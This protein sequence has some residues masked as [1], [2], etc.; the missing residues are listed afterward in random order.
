[1]PVT[2]REIAK[3][4]EAILEVMSSFYVP[5]AG[6]AKLAVQRIEE[7]RRYKA[8]QELLAQ[9]LAEAENAFLEKAKEQGLTDVADW[10]LQMPQQNRPAFK[11]ALEVMLDK[12]SEEPLADLLASEFDSI[13]GLEE[14]ERRRAAA[15]YLTCL[16]SFLLRHESYRPLITALSQLRSEQDARRGCELAE[17]ILWLLTAGMQTLRWPAQPYPAG[18]GL[19][20]YILLAKYRLAPYCG[21]DFEQKRQD[22]LAWAQGLQE[23]RNLFGLRL[24]CGPGGG[25]KTRLLIEAGAALRAA[26]WRVGFVAEAMLDERNAAMLCQEQPQRPTLLILD[27]VE[28][29]Q[30]EVEALLRQMADLRRGNQRQAALAAVLLERR[31]PAWLTGYLNRSRDPGYVDWVEFVGEL[32]P[33]TIDLPVLQ[34][35]EAQ[36]LFDQARQSFAETG[37]LAAGEVSYPA[38]PG[39][40]L[41]VLL[42]AL[43]AAAGRRLEGELSPAKIYEFTWQRERE[44]WERLLRSQA[45]KAVNPDAFFEKAVAALEDLCVLATLGRRFTNQEDAGAFLKAHAGRWQAFGPGG[46]QLSLDWLAGCLP[47]LFPPGALAETLAIA[48]DPLADFVLRLRLAASPELLDLALPLPEEAAQ[49]PEPAAAVFWE[50]L[51]ALTRLWAGEEAEPKRQVTVWIL[52]VDG[53]L[54]KCLDDNLDQNL[55]QEF[56]GVVERFLPRYKEKYHLE[57]FDDVKVQRTIINKYIIKNEFSPN[58]KYLPY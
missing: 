40:P 9:L 22:L 34:P 5:G 21:A 14:E 1:M 50:T 12:W 18:G 30:S 24:Y 52:K 27:Y 57:I 56:L 36:A 35:D 46:E 4:V 20:P 42:L 39:R 41:L 29:R 55:K 43:Q 38:L 7:L 47:D 23:D 58:N 6:A 16:R 54:K 8:A 49:D 37:G 17:Q 3:S 28:N 26:G 25:G 33:Q 45:G 19:R 44:A 11:M 48:P 53:W 2:E 32:R 13:G 10:V 51:G 15:L 31:P